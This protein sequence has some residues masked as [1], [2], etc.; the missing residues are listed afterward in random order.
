MWGERGRGRAKTGHIQTITWWIC[1]KANNL[2]FQLSEKTAEPL[3]NAVAVFAVENDENT[4]F[5]VIYMCVCVCVSD[6]FLVAGF[7]RVCVCVE[8]KKGI[9]RSKKRDLKAFFW[10]ELFPK[11][12]SKE[13][14][15][16][17]IQSG[18]KLFFS[19]LSLLFTSFLCHPF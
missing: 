8:W 2:P 10:L 6:R 18:G 13:D 14:D 4:K 17:N 19:S 9:R 3:Y 15:D 1:H 11:S 12:G 16:K 5:P 7:A